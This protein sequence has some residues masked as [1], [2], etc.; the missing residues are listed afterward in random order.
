M[1][2]FAVERPESCDGDLLLSDDFMRECVSKFSVP[3]RG[4]ETN[5]RTFLRKHLNIV[6]PLKEN[7]NLGRSVNKGKGFRSVSS[8]LLLIRLNS[9]QPMLLGVDVGYWYMS[10]SDTSKYSILRLK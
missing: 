5:Y 8:V 10:K 2:A 3:S 4:N 9:V 1:S 6:D 7:N